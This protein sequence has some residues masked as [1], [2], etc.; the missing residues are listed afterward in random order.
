MFNMNNAVFNVIER[1]KVERK[2]I[3]GDSAVTRMLAPTL[4][5]SLKRQKLIKAVIGPRRSGKST[6]VHQVLSVSCEEYAYINFEDEQ[7]PLDIDYETI[8]LALAKAYPAASWYFFD[9]IQVVPRWE[10]LLNRL[11]RSGRKLVISGS[12]SKLLSSELSST[13]TGRHE[14]F[15]VFPFSYEEYCQAHQGL[16]RNSDLFKQYLLSGGFP[17]VAMGRANSQNY[18]REL[19][20]SIILKDIVQRYR[21]RSVSELKSLMSI[22]RDS[23]S[24]PLSQR[25]LERA[26][27]G[28]ISIAT[29]GKFIGYAQGAYLT[30]MLEGFSFKARERVNSEK[31]AYLVDNGFY[32]GMKVGGQD[33]YGRLLENFVFISLLRR[34]LK[35]NL[36]LFYY[37]TRSGREVD[38]VVLQNG[39]PNSLIQVAWS[40]SSQKTLERELAAISEAAQQLGARE[41]TIITFQEKAVHSSAGV[42]IQVL[43]ITDFDTISV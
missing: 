3:L 27:L 11:E 13:L 16:S 39:K 43:P 42:N 7:L 22:I 18:L 2:Q 29:V 6:L 5:E 17:D 41:A 21:V 24:S 25:S 35:A 26:M 37:K 32:T 12:N 38:F 14:A 23:V 36:D 4:R 34:G 1:Q 31:K 15:E 20:D 8:D 30:F 40:L 28:R 10:Q 19:W 33:D 9:E